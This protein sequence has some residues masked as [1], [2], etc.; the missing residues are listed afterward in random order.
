MELRQRLRIIVPGAA[1]VATL[2]LGAAGVSLASFFAAPE[3]KTIVLFVCSVLL[4]PLFLLLSPV[5]TWVGPPG[6]VPAT[7]LVV[8][9]F[10]VVAVPF[11]PI[12]GSRWA[13]AATILGLIA[14]LLC[15]VIVAGAPA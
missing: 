13:A 8:A 6:S 15:E 11:H 12:S 1:L 7:T 5:R 10:A 4:G 14:W 2:G 3:R 9:V